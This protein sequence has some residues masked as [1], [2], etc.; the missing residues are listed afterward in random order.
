[1]YRATHGSKKF[2]T[3][4]GANDAAK[5]HAMYVTV[6]KT[7]TTGLKRTKKDKKKKKEVA[8]A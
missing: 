4:V 6:L 3:L 8:A 2:S 7:G 1:L 5:F